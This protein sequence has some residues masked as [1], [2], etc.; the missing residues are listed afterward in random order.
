MPRSVLQDVNTPEDVL[1]LLHRSKKI[2]VITGAGVSVSCGI[3][4]FRSKESGLYNTLDCSTFGIPSAELLFDLEF[5]QIDPAPFYQFAPSL[6]PKR[7][8]QPSLCHRFVALLETKKKLLR[9]YTQN[10]DGL[11]R[12]TGMN[13]VLECHGTMAYFHCTGPKCKKKRSL[14]EIE[15]DLK[16]GEVVYCESCDNVMKPGVTFFGETIPKAFDRCLAK[17]VPKVDLVVVIGTSLKVGGSVYE[18]IRQIP[19]RVPQILIN[20]EPVTLPK[21]MSDGF[22]V[23][24]LGNCDDVVDYL[25]ERLMWDIPPYVDQDAVVASTSQQ[26]SLGSDG[27]VGAK[28]SR[29]SQ[30][31]QCS[32][33]RKKIPKGNNQPTFPPSKDWQCSFSSERSFAINPMLE[34]DDAKASS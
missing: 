27:D 26:S 13:H 29:E 9:N 28:R 4:D 7:E 18:L 6:L 8:M 25:S 16:R 31:G 10:V 22:D 30:D 21:S 33:K 32:P 17:D 34:S 14:K 5:F 23:T 1:S 20:K 15:E 3:P 24:L 2:I 11:E 19:D 12:K